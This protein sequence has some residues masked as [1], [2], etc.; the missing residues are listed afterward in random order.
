MVKKDGRREEF[1]A[2]KLRSG[3]TKA[4]AKRPVSAG[5]I[6]AGRF[7]LAAAAGTVPGIQALGSVTPAELEWLYANATLVLIPSRYEG[8]GLPLLEAAARGAAVIASDLPALREIGEGVARF[9]PPSDPAAWAS[10]VKEL[11]VESAERA[12]MGA[13][14]RLRARE[15]DYDRCAGRVEAVVRAVARLPGAVRV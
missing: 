3:I 7:S 8:F 4:C 11:S 1:S 12:R 9:V 5:A 2:I 13:A 15:F 14:G 10:T 6:E